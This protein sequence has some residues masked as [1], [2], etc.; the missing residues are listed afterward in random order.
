MICSQ[1]QDDVEQNHFDPLTLT[2]TG[3][4]PPVEGHPPIPVRERAFVPTELI[5]LFRLAGMT[6]LNMWDG[7]AWNGRH[8]KVRSG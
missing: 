3:T 4:H 8:N 7:T 1:T 2:T 5:L 6:V